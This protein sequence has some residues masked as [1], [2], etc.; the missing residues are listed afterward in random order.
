M[1][2]DEDVGSNSYFILR[3]VNFTRIILYGI[4]VWVQ[5]SLFIVCYMSSMYCDVFTVLVPLFLIFLDMLIIRF[6]RKPFQYFLV[7]SLLVC[8]LSL[9][10]VFQTIFPIFLFPALITLEGYIMVLLSLG[11]GLVSFIELLMLIY[12]TRPQEQKDEDVW[13][14]TIRTYDAQ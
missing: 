4:V 1:A 10:L 13:G 8:V 2:N 3:F 7:A 12:L 9:Y 5:L 14:G 6:S 11:V